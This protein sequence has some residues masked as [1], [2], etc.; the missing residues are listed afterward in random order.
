MLV[1]LLMLLFWAFKMSKYKDH[2]INLHWCL[3][4]VLIVSLLEAI[5]RWSIFLFVNK[6]GFNSIGLVVFQVIV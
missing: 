1:Y 5:L 6:H 4:A 2:I 3:L